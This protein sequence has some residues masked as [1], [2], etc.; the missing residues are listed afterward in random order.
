MKRCMDC[1]HARLVDSLYYPHEWVCDH[2]RSSALVRHCV[3]AGPIYRP[4]TCEKARSGGADAE[5]K[6]Q[7]AA[8]PC[9]PEAKL[10]EEPRGFFDRICHFFRRV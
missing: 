6:E 10:F 4:L 1:R 2:P 5:G 9:G 3:I 8:G 7:Y